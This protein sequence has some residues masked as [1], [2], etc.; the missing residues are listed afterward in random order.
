MD[1]KK[2][3]TPFETI[4]SHQK[5]LNSAIYLWFDSNLTSPLLPPVALTAEPWPLVLG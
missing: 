4:S 3:S 1:Q 2:A 5:P